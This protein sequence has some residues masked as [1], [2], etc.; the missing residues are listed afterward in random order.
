MLLHRFRTK[1]KK[2]VREGLTVD[3][4]IY[5]FRTYCGKWKSPYIS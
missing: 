2:I 4:R 1:E 3:Y 5:I